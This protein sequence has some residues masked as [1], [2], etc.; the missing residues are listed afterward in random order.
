[1]GTNGTA[2]GLRWWSR[3]KSSEAH[4]GKLTARTEGLEFGCEFTARLPRVDSGES[5]F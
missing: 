4:G 1:M 3:V 5:E 2:P